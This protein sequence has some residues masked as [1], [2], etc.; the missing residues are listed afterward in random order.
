M[1]SHTPAPALVVS[2]M[3]QDETIPLLAS[4]G[5]LTRL[6]RKLLHWFDA[7]ARPLPWR[8]DRSPYAIW[9]SEVML[10]QTQVATVIPYFERFLLA[11]PTIERLASAEEQEVIQLWAGLGYYS[12]ARNLHRAARILVNEHGGAW[13]NEVEAASQLPGL[14]RYTVNAILSQAFDLRLPIL[15]ANTRR[16]LARL[17][18][19]GEDPR[20]KDVEA[21]LWNLAEALLPRKRPGDFNQALMEVGALVCRPEKPACSV[22]PLRAWCEAYRMG[23]QNQIPVRAKPKTFEDVREF[24]LIIENHDKLLLTQRPPKG[25]WASMWEFP[26]LVWPA[27]EEANEVSPRLLERLGIKAD[28]QSECAIVRH[29]VTR[30]RISLHCWT[31]VYR[32]GAFQPGLY[33]EARWVSRDSLAGIGLSS[34]QRKLAR[35]LGE[36]RQVQLF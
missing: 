34:P 23:L 24:C 3:P 10:Q 18:A 13:P 30:F 33:A 32:S 11:F 36:P 9:I 19:E 25:R 17:S 21:R 28:V 29:G 14:G 15:E 5:Q 8:S 4:P 7:N 26:H 27:E 2:L 22:C 31:A 16:L 35:M 12:R 1:T 6:R 20:Q